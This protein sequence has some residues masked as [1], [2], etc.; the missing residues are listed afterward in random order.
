[1]ALTSATRR[2]T[3]PHLNQTFD[4]T[5]LFTEEGRIERGINFPALQGFMVLE[6]LLNYI[7]IYFSCLGPSCSKLY[8]YHIQVV[9]YDQVLTVGREVFLLEC[10][11]PDAKGEEF[12]LVTCWI[13]MK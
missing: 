13:S 9:R 6:T 10:L 11:A 3:D 7:S 5:K 1:M 2:S 4:R 8:T 12:A